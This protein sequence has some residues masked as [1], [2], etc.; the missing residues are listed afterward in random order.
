MLET[1]PLETAVAAVAVGVLSKGVPAGLRSI[2]RR[3]WSPGSGSKTL[4]LR[5]IV[6]VVS[7][8]PGAM[9]VPLRYVWSGAVGADGSCG[10]AHLKVDSEPGLHRRYEHALNG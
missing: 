4:A 10:T 7:A 6:F 1:R 2:C 8:P 3:N 5:M 9:E